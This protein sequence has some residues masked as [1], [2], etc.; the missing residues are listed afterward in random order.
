MPLYVCRWGNGDFSV[1]QASNKDHALEML[2]EIANAEGLPL[3]V[4]TDFMAHFRLTDDGTI[5]LE[6]FGD[7]FEG[8]LADHFYPKLSEAQI[9]VH[10]GAGADESWIRA[11]VEVERNRIK[12]KSPTAPDTEIGKKLK[13]Q[14][15]MST[16][17]VN[18][19]VQAAA[20]E[21]LRKTPPPKGKPN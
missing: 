13:S 21:I 4:T 16:V 7:D 6:G 1:V 9:A 10:G 20:K 8:H 14:M 19:K 5:E 15:D 11:A 12:A 2:D 3:H 18:Q 17:V